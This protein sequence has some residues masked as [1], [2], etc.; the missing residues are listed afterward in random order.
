MTRSLQI[1]SVLLVHVLFCFMYLVFDVKSQ[2]FAGQKIEFVF[3]EK[4]VYQILTISLISI[5]AMIAAFITPLKITFRNRNLKRK[6]VEAGFYLFAIPLLIFLFYKIIS[7]G[8]NYG[9]MATERE[10]YSFLIELRIIPYLLFIQYASQNY[11]S[12]RHLVK[13]LTFIAVLALI[14]FQARSLLV[15][16]II[17]MMCLRLRQKNDKFQMKYYLIAFCF[18]P[19]SNIS[20]ALRSGYSLDKYI[21]EMFKFEYLIIFN[22]IV[23]AAMKFEFNQKI[24]WIKERIFLILPS[25]IRKII[26]IENP[27]N[28]MF[29]DV[30]AAANLTSGGFSYLANSYI[31]F[32]YYSAIFLYLIYLTVEIVRR[33][34]FLSK[35][36]NYLSYSFPLMLSCVLLAIRNDAGVLLKQLIQII[37]IAMIM[38][39]ISRVRYRL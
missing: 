34:Y 13:F 19:L 37:I 10:K 16:V 39:M 27:S 15:E 5:L 24:D 35:V 31:L 14:L 21:S 11:I 12:M 30:S 20:I 18:V 9:I 36:D 32:G 29:L 3:D 1:F 8:G 4:S 2:D 38:N 6:R 17:I 33:N 25:P 28:E 22:N 7:S 23:A 26:G